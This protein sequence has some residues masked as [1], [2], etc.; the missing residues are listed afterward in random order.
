MAD[1]ENIMTILNKID[2]YLN[3]ER[4]T[5]TDKKS[6]TKTITQGKTQKFKVKGLDNVEVEARETKEGILFVF[7]KSLTE[8]AASLVDISDAL[9]YD[10]DSQEKGQ[11]S[12]FLVLSK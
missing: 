10:F 1:K 7:D 3:E 11:K 6:I 4:L 5:P 9:G 12:Y 8:L 2:R